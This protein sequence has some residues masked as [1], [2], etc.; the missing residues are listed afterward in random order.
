MDEQDKT[1]VELPILPLRNSV[2]F[3]A[4]VVPVNVGRPRSVKLIEEAFGMDRPSI[5]VVAQLSPTVDDPD[6]EDL[7]SVGTIARILKVIRLSSGN[8]SVLLQGVS[9]MRLLE[10]MSRQPCLRAKVERIPTPQIRDV[11]IDA[12]AT[13]LREAARKVSGQLP[14]APRETGTTLENV[15]NPSVLADLVVSNLPIETDV[16]QRLL[17]TLDLRE[18]MREVI[19]LV[20]RQQEVL[21]MKREISSVVHDEM[22]RSQRE[23]LLRQ[24]MKSIRRELGESEDEEDELETLRDRIVKSEMSLEG[25]KAAKKQLSRLTLMS[26]AG[27]EYHVTRQYVEWLCDLPWAKSTADRMNVAEARRVLDEDHYGL[28]R[29]KKRILEFI[30]VRRLRSDHRGPILCF[31]GPPGVGK[32]SL[33]RSIA[34]ATGRNFQRVALGGVHDES[35][36]RGHRRTYVGAFP[37][38]IITALKKAEAKNP[39][40][41]LDEIDK[42]GKD[43]RGDPS[44]ALL[45]VLDPEQNS[46]FQDH[47]IDVHFNLSRVLFIATANQ[48]HTIPGPLLDRMEL[49]EL[50]GYTRDEKI[51][52]GREFLVPKQ[53]EDHGLTP[54]HFELSDAALARLVDSHTREA[55]VRSLDKKVA[56]LCRDVA[57]QHA[58]GTTTLVHFQGEDV[59]DVLGPPRYEKQ[60]AERKAQIGLATGLAWTAAGG[61]LMPIETRRM[62]GTGQVHVT[63]SAGPIL[64]EAAATAFTY[65]RARAS[66]LGLPED[67]LAKTDVHIHFPQGAVPK[68]GAAAGLCIFVSLTSMLTRVPVRPDVG[69]SGEMT[70]RGSVLRVSGIK[71]KCLTAHR[72]GLKEVVLPAQNAADLE[73]VPD[74]VLEELDIRLISKV[75]EILEL[76][77]DIESQKSPVV[78][79]PA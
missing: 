61:D 40:I 34:R 71:E 14:S 20:T 41:L 17:E 52:I 53:M 23:Y 63:G 51:A 69:I 21:R 31:C 43:N 2:L 37:G 32:T 54:E 18:R 44:S 27:S 12:L 38:R 5:G 13:H 57:V 65:I 56:A 26:P 48:K 42:L 4:A 16:K 64:K 6:F 75:S 70:L 68:D 60:Y 24:Q 29:V 45:E 78:S 62:P 7:H 73:E 8:Y 19:A 22:S 72:A 47:Y 9:R 49:I 39:V 10:F 58:N 67:F 11:E 3:P 55:G 76:T 30:A 79:P 46:T 15:Q 74:E 66:T 25:E 33:A 36:I 35:E 1:S 50:P 59:D 77:L 28:D